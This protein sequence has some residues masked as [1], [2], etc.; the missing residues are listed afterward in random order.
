MRSYKLALGQSYAKL[1]AK[2]E[3]SPLQSYEKL[4]VKLEVSYLRSYEK[5]HVELVFWVQA[6]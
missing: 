3:V 4:Y 6:R 1:Q 2:L 5:L